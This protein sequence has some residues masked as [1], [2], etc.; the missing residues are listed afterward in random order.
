VGELRA[1]RRTG[2]VSIEVPG[3]DKPYMIDLDTYV[4]FQDAGEALGL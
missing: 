4:T 1:E 3:V 2:T